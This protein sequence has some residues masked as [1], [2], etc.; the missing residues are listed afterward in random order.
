MARS[1]GR[2]L[3]AWAGGL[4]QPGRIE[5]LLA[6]ILLIL[7]LVLQIPT[8]QST[9]GMAIDLAICTATAAAA[10]WPKAGGAM[11]AV[12]L[13]VRFFC[14]AE[15]FTMGEYAPLIVVLGAGMRGERRIRA[16]LTAIYVPLLWAISWMLS[17]GDKSV[18]LGDFAWVV[19]IGI[20][21]VIGNAFNTV[22]EAQRQARAA[23]LVLQRQ[24]L[25]R[26][27]HDTVA[28]SFTRVSMIAERAKLRGETS[29]E[30]LASISDEAIRG[31][32]ELRWVM[33]LLR[34]PASSVDALAEGRGSLSDALT[35]GE[36]SLTQD[37][38]SVNLSV[39]GD[40]NQLSQA[41]SE[42]LAAVTAEAV[43]NMSRHG[44][45]AH[46][47]GVVAQIDSDAAELAFINTPAVEPDDE[48]SRERLGVW[49]MRQRL[50]SVNGTVSV[51]LEDQRWVTRVRLPLS[52]GK[53]KG[54]SG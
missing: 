12:L 48:P 18:Y 42:V 37:G 8:R 44:D 2:T 5:I 9:G 20:M 26:E 23:A 25:A 52:V 46:P 51:G 50:E 21:W 7:S 31:V 33:T 47:V 49:G 39:A 53:S 35:A 40:L 30:D 38:F 27:L 43:A 34:D 11:V 24:V 1:A 36:Q 45:P 14:P 28:R 6:M 13:L 22:T 10:R 16:V 3:R 32:E 54:A 41:Q 4:V 17:G 19:L 15:W 29:A